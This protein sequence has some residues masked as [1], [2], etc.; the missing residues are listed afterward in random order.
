M[1]TPTMKAVI[2]TKYGSPEVLKVSQFPIPIPKADEVLIKVHASA[3]TTADTMMRKG[4]PFYARFFLGW[5]RPKNPIIGTGFAGEI[6]AVGS[7]VTQFQ[8]GD[9]VCGE[10]GLQFSANAE[11]VCVSE[12]GVIIQLP[13]NMGYSEAATLCDG[14][15]TSLNFLRNL[16]QI[17]PGHTVLVNGA[18]GS[19]GTAAIQLAK[20]FGAYVIGVCSAKNKALVE[21]LGANEVIN[22][23]TTDFTKLDRRF[24]FVYDAIG[25]SSFAKCKRILQPKGKYL[26]PVLNVALLFQLLWTSITDGQQAKFDATGMRPAEE[27]RQMLQD[28]KIL[29]EQNHLNL[30]IDRTYSM[31]KV[32]EAHQ[33]V[34]SGRKVGNIVLVS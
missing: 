27:L 13:K 12:K 32:V 9:K 8:K 20:Y 11:Y 24:D 16:A 1:K 30:V 15:L 14:P 19:L 7:A 5:N 34:D 21:S 31:E 28:L 17:Q 18:S 10:S 6:I 4:T 3:A 25:K 23:Q 22:Y 26:S 33:Y 2:C 29:I